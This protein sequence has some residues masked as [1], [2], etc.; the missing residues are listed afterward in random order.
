MKNFFLFLLVVVAFSFSSCH[1]MVDARV[2]FYV[3]NAGS[4]GKWDHISVQLGSQSKSFFTPERRNMSKSGCSEEEYSV[5]FY[6]SPGTY[7]YS[8]SNGAWKGSITVDNNDCKLV[9]LK[10]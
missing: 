9:G 5:T 8:A 4:A 6:L 7:S 10:Y 1:K 3:S 2:T